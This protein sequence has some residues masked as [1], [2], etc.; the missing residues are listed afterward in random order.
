MSQRIYKQQT[1]YVSSIY[2]GEGEG[3]SLSCV[4]WEAGAGGSGQAGGQLWDEGVL[5]MW[6]KICIKELSLSVSDA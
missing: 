6:Q 5:P 3:L 2:W 4:P 1:A